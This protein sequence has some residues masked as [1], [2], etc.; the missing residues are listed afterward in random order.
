MIMTSEHDKLDHHVE[1]F[2]RQVPRHVVANAQGNLQPNNWLGLL[3][4]LVFI[5]VDAFSKVGNEGGIELS[6][7]FSKHN[8]Y[9]V[10][11]VATRGA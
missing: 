11:K 4:C 10:F 9:W 8:L 7:D 1:D 6:P 5:K 3:N 2:I